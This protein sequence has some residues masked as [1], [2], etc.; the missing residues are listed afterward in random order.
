M[1][2]IQRLMLGILS[3]CKVGTGHWAHDLGIFTTCSTSET[4]IASR[5]FF[6]MIFFFW[7]VFSTWLHRLRLWERTKNSATKPRKWRIHSV[8]KLKHSSR[9]HSPW[10][11]VEHSWNIENIQTQKPFVTSNTSPWHAVHV[12]STKQKI[13]LKVVRENAIC[14]DK[15]VRIT[16]VLLLANLKSGEEKNNVF[17]F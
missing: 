4:P 9:G 5:L 1:P 8:E 13:I 16:S 3:L 14:K 17:P 12:K 15:Y 6:M 7:L 2:S 11:Y 10:N